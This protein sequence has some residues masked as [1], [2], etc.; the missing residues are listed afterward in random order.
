[1]SLDQ[2]LQTQT[3]EVEFKIHP[4][5]RTKHDRELNKNR[6]WN[7]ELSGWM[8]RVLNVVISDFFGSKS[9]KHL[10]T[11]SPHSNSSGQEFL[12]IA[13]QTTGKATLLDALGVQLRPIS[14]W[15]PFWG[16]DGG[17]N[18]EMFISSLHAVP[19]K[20]PGQGSIVEWF[21][22]Q[23]SNPNPLGLLHQ[24]FGS[25]KIIIFPMEIALCS[26]F[27]FQTNQKWLPQCFHDLRSSG[28]FRE[29]LSF[30]A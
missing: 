7:Y 2:A 28:I 14:S 5:S 25:S 16:P 6:N 26:L 18:L 8:N 21:T 22:L 20:S 23:I 4:I 17:V 1:M 29:H 27:H 3:I 11:A 12:H 19:S 9:R 15:A 24:I 30:F 13:P 10:P